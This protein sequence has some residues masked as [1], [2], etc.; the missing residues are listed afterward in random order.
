MNIYQSEN[1]YRRYD[2][3][4]RFACQLSTVLYLTWAIWSFSRRVKSLGSWGPVQVMAVSRMWAI[5]GP[6]LSTGKLSTRS[7]APPRPERLAPSPRAGARKKPCHSQIQNKP[8]PPDVHLVIQ[9]VRG[10]GRHPA[11]HQFGELSDVHPPPAE[12]REHAR[13]TPDMRGC[14]R[15]SVIDV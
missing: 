15:M 3:P 4:S 11:L 9:L 10:V 14:D 7:G 8:F 12:P 2:A 1:I 6:C 5:T 13:V